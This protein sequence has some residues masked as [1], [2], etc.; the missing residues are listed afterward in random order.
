MLVS[1]SGFT[2]KPHKLTLLFVKINCSKILNRNIRS[3]GGWTVQALTR[4]CYDVRTRSSTRKQDKRKKCYGK[5][6]PVFFPR[7]NSISC[8]GSEL[9]YFF[10]CCFHSHAFETY[11]SRLP[12]CGHMST[13]FNLEEEM[14][15]LTSVVIAWPLVWSLVILPQ[16]SNTDV[17]NVATRE[18]GA[19]A[20]APKQM[21]RKGERIVEGKSMYM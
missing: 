14:G 21:L 10:I 15:D 12:C 17:I 2:F 3:A 5:L 18:R 11:I 13:W 16:T 7:Q 1:W 20:H 9:M 8:F 19:G 4:Y 6:H